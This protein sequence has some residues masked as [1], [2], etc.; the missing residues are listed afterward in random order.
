[1]PTNK[2]DFDKCERCRKIPATIE[3][4]ECGAAAGTRPM[5]F[6]YECDKNYHKMLDKDRHARGPIK[7]DSSVSKLTWFDPLS[8]PINSSCCFR[9]Y[10]QM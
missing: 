2:L 8:R 1:M 3:C 9:V 6:C 5:K 4:V 7:F 10:F